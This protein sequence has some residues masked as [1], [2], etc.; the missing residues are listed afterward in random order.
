[1]FAVFV[2]A[3][4]RTMTSR[5]LIPLPFSPLQW[6]DAERSLFSHS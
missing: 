6:W 4:L 5:V 1:V 3:L 2:V